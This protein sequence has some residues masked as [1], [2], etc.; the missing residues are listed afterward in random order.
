MQFSPIVIS[1]NS[2]QASVIANAIVAARTN[3]NL[4]PKQ[5]F[6]NIGDILSTPQLTVQ[7]PYLNLNTASQI[8]YAINDQ[9]YE[10]IPS[11]LL[12]VLRMDSLGQ[13]ISSNGQTQ[14]QFS[15]YDGHQYAVESSTDLL[16]WTNMSTNSPTNGVFTV[17]MPFTANGTN[18]FYRT[19]LI[20]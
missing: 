10:A 12:P 20:Q 3:T 14:I 4:F 15:G 5:I 17:G 2:T 6:R 1:S 16:A 8:S 13:I 11:Q 7:S 19:V 9:A 18:Q